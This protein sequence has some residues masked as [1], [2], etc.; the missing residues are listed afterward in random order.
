[1]PPLPHNLDYVPQIYAEYED[2]GQEHLKGNPC[3]KGIT[4]L[5]K[6]VIDSDILEPLRI[7]D[8]R[9]SSPMP[10]IELALSSASSMST[11]SSNNLFLEDTKKILNERLKSIDNINSSPPPTKESSFRS[12]LDSIID[13]FTRNCLNFNGDGEDRYYPDPTSLEI[14][15]NDSFGDAETLSSISTPSKSGGLVEE[16]YLP[17]VEM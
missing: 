2:V 9:P 3:V 11:P 15:M 4:S 8:D 12:A 7:N 1:M 17:W 6:D 5:T 10:P 13:V 16:Y 14:D